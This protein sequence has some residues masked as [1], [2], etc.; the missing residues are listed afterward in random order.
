MVQN[1]LQP[2]ESALVKSVQLKGFIVSSFCLSHPNGRVHRSP[3]AGRIVF[4]LE[5]PARDPPRLHKRDP[6]EEGY[7]RQLFPPIN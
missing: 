3:D 6:G 4:V 5:N 7:W 2:S 1:I